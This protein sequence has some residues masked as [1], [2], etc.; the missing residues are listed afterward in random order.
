MSCRDFKDRDDVLCHYDDH[1]DDIRDD[2]RT[3][4][5]CMKSRRDSGTVRKLF[6]TVRKTL[7][8]QS[9]NAFP[10]P[11]SRQDFPVNIL[12]PLVQNS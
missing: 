8:N 7:F 12:D 9:E 3:T 4:H 1:H 2:H 6:P 11:K 5:S 10:F